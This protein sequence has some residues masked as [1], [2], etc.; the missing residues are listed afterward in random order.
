MKIKDE[1]ARLCKASE[2]EEV[3]KR[4]TGRILGPWHDFLEEKRKK[5]P[6]CRLCHM[7]IEHMPY[8]GIYSER[9]REHFVRVHWPG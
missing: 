9:L 1:V 5:T 6:D 7:P 4:L 2:D 3:Q 8:A